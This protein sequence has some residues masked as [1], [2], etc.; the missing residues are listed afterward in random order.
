LEV[1]EVPDRVRKKTDSGLP[2][3][4]HQLSI[5]RCRRQVFAA[6]G[7]EING[8]IRRSGRADAAHATE[9]G[10]GEWREQY[11]IPA[12][13]GAAVPALMRR[14]RQVRSSGLRSRDEWN[15]RQE[16]E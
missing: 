6:R 13:S 14:L 15:E 5:K 1:G 3:S 4:R 16:G 12:G 8:I 10:F 7:V 2:S 11:A 9:R